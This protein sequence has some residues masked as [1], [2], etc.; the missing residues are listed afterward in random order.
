MILK[1]LFLFLFCFVFTLSNA[2][3]INSGAELNKIK[4]TIETAPKAHPR[5]FISQ[6]EISE[7]HRRI[8]SNKLLQKAFM[9]LL[10]QANELI[11][12]QPYNYICS[13][14]ANLRMSRIALKR[15]SYLS[16]A[17]LFTGDHRF[18]E[19]GRDEMLAVAK[20]KDWN[21]HH[22]LDVAE[23]TA[24][25]AIGYD[26]LY[27]GLSENARGTIE[28]AI[29]KKGLLPLF[30]IHNFSWTSR[31]TCWT[32]VSYSGLVLGALSIMEDEP[33]LAAK[34]INHALPGIRRSMNAYGSNGG[35]AEGPE[36]W[37]YGTT[38]NVLMIDALISALKTDFALSKIKPFMESGRYFLQATDPVGGVFNYGDC[39]PY[40]D[41]APVMYW[42]AYKQQQPD[43]LWI[44]RQKLVELVDTKPIA[45]DEI[46]PYMVFT[47]LWCH[48]LDSVKPVDLHQ[49]VLGQ[50]PVG[51]HHSGWERNSVFIGI[52]GGTQKK[53]HAHMDIGSFVV[54]A[55]NIR[56]AVDLGFE[57]Y[58][59]LQANNIDLWNYHQNSDRW[60]VFRLGS[61]SHNTLVVDGNLQSVSGF[62]RIIGFSDKNPLP[63]TIIDMSPAYQGQL[64]KAIRGIGLMID[65][66]IIIQD[67]IVA[68]KKH[69]SIRWGMVTC[70]EVEKIEGNWAILKQS[71]KQLNFK[72]LEP[73]NSKIILF[74]T[75][76]PPNNFDG[77]N[78]GTRMIG[79]ETK[80]RAFEN[81]RLVVILT[82]GEQREDTVYVTPLSQ[83]Q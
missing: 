75:E 14:H 67:E 29:T 44:E 33:K 9:R 31:N 32:Q 57:N 50:T 12:L 7:I 30:S 82:P 38:Y 16:F 76:K 25:M 8:D 83:W 6:N 19:H 45:W 20:L 37:L 34:V 26:W 54:V 70:A 58:S 11:D 10:Q 46:E 62:A 4:E 63:H 73:S 66:R 77:S 53:S 27:N 18:L 74:E 60:R 80:V 56:W 69:H 24:A 49:Q 23:M 36:Y 42:F 17:F 43:L 5:L 39:E 71:G 47:F 78:P 1:R 22:F 52:K 55:D 51:F 40:L 3:C 48:S 35:Y 21:P 13:G 64:N 28:R 2:S 81:K 65:R 59:F 61:L 79:F 72:I 15:I 41:V 68:D